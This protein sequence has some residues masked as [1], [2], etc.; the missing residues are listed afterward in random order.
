MC[1]MHKHVFSP[2]KSFKVLSVRSTN[3]LS[4]ADVSK[5]SLLKVCI[6]KSQRNCGISNTDEFKSTNMQQYVLATKRLSM[7]Q[8]VSRPLTI[9]EGNKDVAAATGSIPNLYPTSARRRSC[10]YR[11]RGE[12][13]LSPNQAADRRQTIQFST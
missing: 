8:D 4:L 7:S 6:E 1:N 13:Q 5:C 9:P 11:Y 2:L 12:K 3:T 10:S